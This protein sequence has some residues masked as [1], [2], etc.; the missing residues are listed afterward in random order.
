[1]YEPLIMEH[2]VVEVVS[3]VNLGW[4]FVQGLM[5]SEVAQLASCRSDKRFGG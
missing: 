5:D 4:G 2:R 3:V 1:M